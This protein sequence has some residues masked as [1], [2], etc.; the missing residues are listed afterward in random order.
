MTILCDISYEQSGTR[1]YIWV[2]NLYFTRFQKSC[3]IER[4]KDDN[5]FVFFRKI[6]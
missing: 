3:L 1:L 5:N 6:M 4:F 2:V